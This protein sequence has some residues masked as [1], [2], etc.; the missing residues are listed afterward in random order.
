MPES[1]SSGFL[2]AK[3]TGEIFSESR[4][5]LEW[6]EYSGRW[7]PIFLKSFLKIDRN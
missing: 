4:Y 2:L 7:Q 5:S 6:Q 3:V 1:A